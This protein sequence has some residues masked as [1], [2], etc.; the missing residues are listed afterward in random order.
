MEKIDSLK[1]FPQPGKTECGPAAISASISIYRDYADRFDIESIIR[2]A[3]I[4]ETIKNGANV[5]QLAKGVEVLSNKELIL[6]YKI[7]G[8]IKDLQTV[9]GQDIPAVVDW[10][11][12]TFIGSDGGRGHY[13]LITRIYGDEIQM[14]DSLP[15]FP[16]GRTILIQE[17]EKLWWD[18]DSVVDRQ[19]N[20]KTIT[21]NNLFFIVIPRLQAPEFIQ[22]LKM[23][24][25]NK[26]PKVL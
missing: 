5:K 22:K 6:V 15:E 11:G 2:S 13:S 24:P 20:E 18:T 21:T 7:G 16:E 26:F 4:V 17:F 10:Q 19:G 1:R 12:S 3:G 23:L 14:V 9:I 25:G 8:T